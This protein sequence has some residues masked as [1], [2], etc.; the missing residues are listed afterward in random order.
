M[1][2]LSRVVPV[3]VG[4]GLASCAGVD[5]GT[6]Y[7]PAAVERI[8]NFRTYSWLEQ[9]QKSQDTRINNAIVDARVKEAVNQ[10]LQ[11]RG[12]RKVDASEN[13]DFL[14][15]WQGAIDTRLSADTVDNYYGYPWDPFWG[16]YYGPY[17]GG[18]TYV[19]Q[20]DVGTLILDVVDTKAKALVWR[21]TAQTDLGDTPSAQATG[22]KLDEGVEK[23]LERFPPKAEKPK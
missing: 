1:R 22:K 10:D 19:R 4:L 12:Y 15:G 13:P 9:P 16:S 20:Y 8:D 2:L 23:M 11:S 17:G 3:L 14:I 7:D 5:V 6:N 18:A 21:G